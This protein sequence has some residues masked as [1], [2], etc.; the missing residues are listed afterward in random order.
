M[1]VRES[2]QVSVGTRSAASTAPTDPA[3]SASRNSPEALARMGTGGFSGAKAGPWRK[4]K[5]TFTLTFT[6]TNPPIS[7]LLAPIFYLNLP[8]RPGHALDSRI[9]PR[10]LTA[11]GQGGG[12]HSKILVKVR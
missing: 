11:C 8:L 9:L 1:V 5:T 4:F 7:H 3:Q 6:S 2:V 12:G 10:G